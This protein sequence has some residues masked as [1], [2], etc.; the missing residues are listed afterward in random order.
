[1]NTS[2]YLQGSKELKSIYVRVRD[3][4][5]DAK[6]NTK[7]KVNPKHFKNGS[8]K[9]VSIPANCSAETKN[10][11]LKQNKDLKELQSQ[12]NKIRETVTSAYNRLKSYEII[13]T[14]WLK[15]V[16]DPKKEYEVP[17]TL[18]DYFQYYVDFKSTSI[19][20]STIK[21]INVFK[22]RLIN[23][24]KDVGRTIYIQEVNKKF[25]FSIQKWCDEQGYAHNTKVQTLKVILTICNHASEN[26][27]ETSRELK[28][29]TKS[30]KY[31]EVE[32]ITLSF[33]E[34]QQ[35]I[36]TKILDEKLNVAKDWLII[37]CY[38]AQRISDNLYLRKENIIKQG[39]NYI[40]HFRQQKTD[41]PISISLDDEVVKILKKRKG[42]FPPI[43]SDSKESNEVIYNKLIKTVC[44][45]AKIN[46]LVKAN[47]RNP[48]T[49]RYEIKEVPKYKAVTSH[50]GRRSFATNY[51][52]LIPTALL[53]GQTGHSSEI[54]FL[55][56]VGKKGNQNALNLAEKMKEVKQNLQKSREKTKV[57]PLNKTVNG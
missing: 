33:D 17:N 38:T 21:K 36:D 14:Q 23:Y 27:I 47:I 4:D 15:N 31:K 28:Y 37:S 40:L 7:L 44:R 49:N 9:S 16:L 5:F 53:I 45:M 43:F 46:T 1:M 32:N 18:V 51:Y 56:Y 41:K 22:N 30:L 34:I 24:Q 8:T 52:G 35:I 39:D 12:L 20:G 2:F 10:L 3:T 13:N 29:I 48:E 42:E 11:I 54:Q 26:G 50:I 25:S 6:T 19:K 57:V 55:R